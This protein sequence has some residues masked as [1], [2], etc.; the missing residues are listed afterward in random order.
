MYDGVRNALLNGKNPLAFTTNAPRTENDQHQYFGE[1]TK[2]F[3]MQNAQY[4]SNLFTAQ[5]QGMDYEN[6]YDY[7]DVRIRVAQV[8]D[9]TTGQN[10]GD[11]WRRIMIENTNLD[12]IPRGAKVVYN[13][14]TW[15]VTNPD[16]IASV[17]GTA[18]IKRCNATWHHLDWYGNILTEPFCYGQ[19]S[20]DLATANNIKIN[21]ILLDAYQHCSMQLNPDT[22]ELAHNRRLLLGDQAYSVRGLQ[23]FVQEIGDDLNSV[24]IQFFDVS[25][26]EALRA[27]DDI[28][29][30]VA[31]GLG[32]SWTINL[33]GTS[34]MV[35]GNTQTLKATSVRNGITLVTDSENAVHVKLSVNEEGLPEWIP[36]DGTE[37]EGV[38][39]HEVSYL[40]E[41][42]DEEVATVDEDGKVTAI[43][44]GDVT[45][46]CK[47]QQNEAISATM[48]VTVTE[49]AAEP[50]LV[51]E[52]E[53]PTRAAQYQAV[54]FKAVLI[55]D[56]EPSDEPVAY[57][58]SGASE[59][60]Y[61]V[62]IDGNT[63]TLTAYTLPKKPLEVQAE[64]NGMTLTASIAFVGW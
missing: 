2:Q 24:H 50:T 22:R 32:F 62:A 28:T 31:D 11:D 18:I 48:S 20:N 56:G 4:A 52:T 59:R 26:E 39:L 55:V 1:A 21:M 34:E 6:F 61:S 29:N 19:G 41:S 63:V 27:I 58:F 60:D 40:W 42:S 37:T 43:A 36:V 57:T 13:G 30:R 15:L 9:P 7:T 5:I 23:N 51:W 17:S 45:I 33:S 8:I 25:R 16:N 47:L 46:T 38:L 35:A 14:N 12:F 64:C 44:A 10:L 53:P 3:I 54:T 49:T